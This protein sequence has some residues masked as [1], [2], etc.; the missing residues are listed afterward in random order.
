MTRNFMIRILITAITGSV[1]GYITNWLAIKM[2]FKPHTEKRIFGMKVPFTPGLIPKEK[3]RIAKSVGDAIGDHLLTSETL[4][5]SLCSEEMNGKL[6]K[7]VEDK[8]KAIEDSGAT[9]KE[10]LSLLLGNKY[11]IAKEYLQDKLSKFIFTSIKSDEFVKEIKTTTFNLISKEISKNPSTILDNQLYLSLKENILGKTI[12]Y[13]DS[14]EFKILLANGIENKILDLN[15]SKV[16]VE[17]VIPKGIVG[18][19]KVVM[20]NRREDISLFIKDFIKKDSIQI[21]LK[22]TVFEMINQNLNPMM[23]MFI[24]PE[25]IYDKAIKAIYAK[26]E[27]EESQR[28]I[29]LVINNLI[30]TILKNNISTL[31]KEFADNKIKDNSA[32]LAEFIQ[33][34]V[35]T[36]E[37]LEKVESAIENKIESVD[38]IQ[39]LL[40]GINVDANQIIGKLID[41]LLEKLNTNGELETKITQWV[42]NTINKAEMLTINDIST[43]SGKNI[44]NIA[45]DFAEDVYDKFIENN[46]EEF[47][48]ALEIRKIVEDKINDFEVSY[49]EKIILEIAS[50][51]LNA[52]T[53]LGALLG[54]IMGLLSALMSNF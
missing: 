5:E 38:T 26:L 34:K 1:I 52:I 33:G 48:N 9:L 27:E 40:Q 4:I 49:A 42:N 10:Q 6:K 28:D 12:E 13:K 3:A 15:N 18:S 45:S 19:A 43:W 20:Y 46:A 17:E 23:A 16:T 30:D 7:W 21:K 24:N 25:S 51:E 22:E 36:N 53:W 32:Y 2:L 35:I 37:I 50:K 39:E 8:I 14:S 31:T 47:L 54:L 11:C 44:S 29:V 41:S